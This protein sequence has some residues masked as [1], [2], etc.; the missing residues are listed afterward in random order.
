MYVLLSDPLINCLYCCFNSVCQYIATTHLK[1]FEKADAKDKNMEMLQEAVNLTK[2]IQQ[3]EKED[4]KEKF[5]SANAGRRK[6]VAN[7]HGFHKKVQ[8][9]GQDLNLEKQFKKNLEQLGKLTKYWI[10]L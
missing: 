7:L 3:P 9:E 1:F 5:I 6:T 2:Q 10:E 4:K 8:R